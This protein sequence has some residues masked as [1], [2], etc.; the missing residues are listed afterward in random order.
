MKTIRLFTAFALV[1]LAATVSSRAAEPGC[2]AE[3]TCAAA[4]VCDPGT[5]CPKCG[6]H[7]GLIPVCH[8]YCA[9]KKVVKYKYCCKCTELCVPGR[10]PCCSSCGDCGCNGGCGQQGC[11]DNGGCE[12]GHC[13]CLVR[14]VHQM[15]KIPYTVEV[16]VRKCN[17]TWVCPSCG[18]D[19]GCTE[20]PA[21]PAVPAAPGPAAPTPAP[22]AP[23]KSA[24][25]PQTSGAG[26]A[27]FFGIGGRDQAAK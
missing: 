2:N 25:A 13:N 18:C 7:E 10:F 12:S 19:C 24:T 26:L 16:P 1:A 6:C 20:M 17:V 4:P 9:T 3:P 15:V 5:C 27:A 11:C 14:D 8:P 22:P 21:T 23:P